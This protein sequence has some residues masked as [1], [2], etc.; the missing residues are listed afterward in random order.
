MAELGESTLTRVERKQRTRR[1]ILD[2]A[3]LLSAE[4]GGLSTLSLRNLAREVGVVPTAFY[5]HFGSVE[6]LGLALVEESFGSLR[7][8]LRD[9]RRNTPEPGEIINR[10]V[11]LLRD[12]V[13][14]RREHFGFLTRESVIGPGA[15]RAAVRHQLELFE[16]ELATDL[17]RIGELRTW[18]TDDLNVLANMIVVLMFATT[19][20]ILSASPTGIEAVSRRAERQLRMLVVGIG[21]WR[22]GR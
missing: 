10:S 16:R 9:A 1:A 11:E 12:H 13:L 5:R 4:G 18:S 2:A 17:A 20:E 8:V 22:S 15:V 7:E 14:E 19:N 3:L 21:Q 6:E